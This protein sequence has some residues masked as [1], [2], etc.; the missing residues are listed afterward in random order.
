M[1]EMSLTASILDIVHEQALKHRFTKV[2]TLTLS[3]GA[4][5]C[6]EPRSL[7]FAF[8]VLSQETPA[9][10]ARLEFD[11]LPVVIRCLACEQESIVDDFPC[12]CPG[13]EA[14][15]VILMGGTEEL[16]LLEM[17]VEEE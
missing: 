8:E 16:K 15:D 2:N 13:C 9:Q 11:V 10:G 12:R 1:H 4:L 14:S 17:D 5:S 7:E 6:I 3:Y